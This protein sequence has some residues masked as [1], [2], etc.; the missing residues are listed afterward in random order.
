MGHLRSLNQRAPAIRINS[1]DGCDC[2][3]AEDFKLCRLKACFTEYMSGRVQALLCF[4]HVLQRMRQLA[5]EC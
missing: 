2:S 4:V 3:L 5:L 1:P